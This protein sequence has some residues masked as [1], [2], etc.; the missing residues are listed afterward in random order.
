MAVEF[1]ITQSDNWFVGEDKT[2]LVDVVQSDGSTPQAMTGWALTHEIMD[3]AG[4][5]VQLSHTVG[6]GITIGNGDG[7]NDRATV[8]I[9][10][11]EGETLGAG[12]YYHR[13]RRTDA[14]SEQMLSFGSAVLKENAGT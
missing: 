1:N 13:L 10:D 12:T 9:T 2:F 7:T 8:T 5:T 3:R 11:A 6:D 4:G 14:G